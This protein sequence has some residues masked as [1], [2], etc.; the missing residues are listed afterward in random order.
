MLG[1]DE[2]FYYE[3]KKNRPD[4]N[5]SKLSLMGSKGSRITITAVFICDSNV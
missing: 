5:H 2:F 4:V 3:N 1:T